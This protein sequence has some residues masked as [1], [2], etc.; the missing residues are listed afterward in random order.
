M[1]GEEMEFAC[2]T[3]VLAPFSFTN[4]SYFR[5]S[6]EKTLPCFSR[7]VG[8][9][10]VLVIL[11]V[12]FSICCV[13]RKP[14]D[15]LSEEMLGLLMCIPQLLSLLAVVN[16]AV[17]FAFADADSSVLCRH[18]IGVAGFHSSLPSAFSKVQVGHEDGISSGQA[19]LPV[20]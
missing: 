6:L 10:L 16:S 3:S 5:Y 4:Y 15:A 7:A 13:Y 9:S 12:A 19:M 8:Q 2:G 18:L 11:A 1:S 20:Q 17:T 14:T